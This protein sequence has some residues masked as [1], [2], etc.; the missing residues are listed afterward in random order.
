[1]CTGRQKR[2]LTPRRSDCRI[3]TSEENPSHLAFRMSQL[4]CPQ[5]R[6]KKKKKVKK[7]ISFKKTEEKVAKSHYKVFSVKA[8]GHM[9]KVLFFNVK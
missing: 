7:K 6:G 4:A 9:E 3:Q 2:L 8:R 5:W 1:M